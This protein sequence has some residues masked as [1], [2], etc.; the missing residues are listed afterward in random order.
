MPDIASIMNEVN[1]WPMDDRII[2]L[3]SIK[4]TIPN[5]DAPPLSQEW[6]D[7]I[8]RRVADLD[9]GKAKTVS[10]EVVRERARKRL[11][12]SQP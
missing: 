8:D 5:Y 2:L 9:A 7:E 4:E 11:Q 12:E 1:Q 3:E 6:I 10:W